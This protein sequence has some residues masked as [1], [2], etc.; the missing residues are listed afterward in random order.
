MILMADAV[1]LIFLRPAVTTI[2]LLV[3]NTK[4]TYSSFC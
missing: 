2:Q 1:S 4:H 3:H